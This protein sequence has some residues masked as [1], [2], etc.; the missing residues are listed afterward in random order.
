MNTFIPNKASSKNAAFTYPRK[1]KQAFKLVGCLAII[2]FYGSLTA[3]AITLSS[4]T[5]KRD[6]TRLSHHIINHAFD[7]IFEEN[8]RLSLAGNEYFQPLKTQLVADLSPNFILFSTPKS[9][10]FFEF[11]S[12]VK[13]RLMDTR[14]APV[15][16]PSYMPNANIF[17]RLNEDVFKPKFLSLG[18]S[19]HSNGARG[20]S[21]NKDGTFNVDSGKFTTNFYTL[22]Y[23]TGKRVDK[24][25][26]TINR[27][28]NVALEVHAGLFNLGLSQGLKD[29]Y[30]FVRI[31]GS[32]M[33][34]F[35]KAYDDPLEQGRKTYENWQRVQFD[36]TY[37]ADKYDNYSTF[38]VKKRL[39]VSL[40][41]YYSFPFMQGT[42]FMVG[43]G[44]RGQDDYNQSFQD[45]YGYGMVGIAANL[46]FGFHKHVE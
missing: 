5:S 46:S 23:Y 22:T 21:L 8:M 14:D 37:I 26:L 24:P 17:Y 39:N 10:F 15:K 16:S 2:V 35:V 27:Y 7:N 45:S 29:H 11:T 30:G 3:N 31:N 41:Y 34:N 44:Y 18:Y 28:D 4:D 20:P 19:H 42:A 12:R 9:R 13:I 1:L 33:Y 38:D 40:K 43:A 25:G 36:F 6:S 32:R